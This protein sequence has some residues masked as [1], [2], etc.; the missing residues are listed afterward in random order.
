MM[1]AVLIVLSFLIIRPFLLAIFLGGLLAYVAYPL[2]KLVRRRIKNRGWAAMLVCLVIFIL[3]IIPA[4][5]FV[6]SLVQE[7]YAL[8]VLG[9]QKFSVG[10]FSDCSNT[11]CSQL[12]ELSEN[13]EVKYYFQEGLKGLT[14]WV[15]RKGSDLLIGIPTILLNLFVV[16]FTLFY[17]LK[18]GKRFF[19]KVSS[20]LS[21]QKKRYMRIVGRLEEITYALVFGYILIALVQGALGAI[22]FFIFGVSSPLFWGVVMAFLALMP[23]LGTGL[24]WGPAGVI[25]VL[26]GIFQDSNFLIYKGIGLLAYGLLV[27]SSIDNLIKPK[28]IGDRAKVHPSLI[29]IGILG[30]IFLLGPIGVIAGPLILSL[31]AIVV[32]EYLPNKEVK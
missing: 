2:F 1:F 32:E 13:P 29:L 15:I 26:E 10:L 16:F 14:N 21:M 31:T 19:R 22:G 24:V 11:F 20:Y 9:K 28:L 5:F 12:K 25:I 30:G 27:I 23:Y 7:S 18:D 17:F 6:K 8:Y 4:I 3:I